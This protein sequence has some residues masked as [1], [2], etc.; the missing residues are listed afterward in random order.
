MATFVNTP[1]GTWKGVFRNPGRS[2][3]VKTLPM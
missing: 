3:T 1:A 2:P